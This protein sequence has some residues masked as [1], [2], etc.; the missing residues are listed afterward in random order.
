MR[1][2]W[3]LVL[4]SLALAGCTRKSPPA[5]E[6]PERTE[7]A[8]PLETAGSSE[9]T[10]PGFRALAQSFFLAEL[11][12]TPPLGVGLGL[13]EYDGR[14]PDFSKAA[15]EATVARLRRDRAR[16]EAMTLDDPQEAYERQVI[17]NEAR[18]MLFELD[19]LREPFRNP[20]FYTDAPSLL[21]YVSREY[22]PA[23]ARAAAIIRLCEGVPAF[24]EVAKQNLKTPIPRTFIK[25]ALLQVRGMRSFAKED[26]PAA[27]AA[28][29]PSD[30][31]KLAA[32]LMTCDRGLAD[33]E[34]YLVKEEARGTDNF[35]LGADLFVKMLV[36]TEGLEVDLDRLEAIGRADLERNLA[37]LRSAAKRMGLG[38]EAAVKKV[39]ADKPAASEVLQTAAEQAEAMRRFVLEKDIVSIPGEDVAV[40][41]ESPAFMRWNSAFLSSAGFFEPKPLPSFYYI[42]PPDPSWSEAVQRDY[43][44]SRSD[45]LFI[46]IHEVWPGHFLHGL[47]AKAGT[48]DIGKAFCSYAMAEGWAHYT[49]EMM[50]DAGVGNN[51][52]EV[53]IGQLQ[54][55]LLRNV[56]F[57][58][59]IGLHARGMTVEAS[60]AMFMRDGLQ[61]EGNAEQQAVRGTFD[62]GYLKYTLGK[63]IIR[64]LHADW[65]EK[66]GA[67]YSP[68]RFHDTFLSYQCAP[69]PAI[70]A[71]M[72]GDAG[73]AL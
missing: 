40:V 45:L 43:V 6:P 7:P 26:V 67:A 32:G 61:D 36:E 29:P 57:I 55:A 59:A 44:P 63:L 37:S 5:E 28:L 22:A 35:A 49:E 66:E 34:A 13:H 16:F 51:S 60:K 41:V 68:R 71:L 70:R 58:S 4:L 53:H 73:G 8:K 14:L 62:P 15:L 21:E 33:F 72:L 20:M 24:F 30:K 2:F 18:T 69:L 46:T 64:K 52:P 23:E 47:H 48:S 42:S 10:G 19:T 11:E 31:A 12:S 56:R 3:T 17:L 1:N 50:Y 38:V 25:T 54:N 9:T 65:R 39:T 27:F